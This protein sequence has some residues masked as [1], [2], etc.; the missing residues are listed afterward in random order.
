MGRKTKIF[1]TSNFR[2]ELAELSNSNV[3]IYFDIENDKTYKEILKILKN[4]GRKRIKTIVAV[5]LRNIYL[6]NIYK[7][8]DKNVTAIK[9]KSGISKNQEYRIYCRE[10]FQDGKKVVM[11]SPF[12]KKVNRNQDDKRIIE[13]I[14]KI[15]TYNYE[16]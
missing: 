15:K 1:N 6:D 7:I 11:I 13:I 16:F 12:L 3:E 9:V 14:N 4:A 5:I 2:K 10:I 8:E